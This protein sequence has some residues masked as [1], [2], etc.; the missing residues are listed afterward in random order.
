MKNIAIFTIS[1]DIHAGV[2]ADEITALGANCYVV[3]SDKLISHGGLSANITKGTY[4]INDRHGRAFDIG[5][6]DVV[7]WRRAVRAQTIES[8]D[9]PDVQREVINNDCEATLLGMLFA[10]FT[11]V[12]ISHPM[13]T[14]M[15]ANK[16]WQGKLAEECGLLHPKT[17]VSQNPD[18]VYEFIRELEGRIIIKPVHGTIKLPLYTQLL[19]MNNL[20]TRD[21]I[22]VC[23]TIYQELIPGK[24]HFRINIF[25]NKVYA[26]KLESDDLDW[27]P[28]LTIPFELAE[29]PH[30]LVWRLKRMIDGMG[31]RMGIVDMKYHEVNGGIYFLEVNPQGQFLFLQAITGFDLAKE[32]AHFLVNYSDEQHET[33]LSSESIGRF[34]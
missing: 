19:D 7:W 9:F 15:A 8:D 2:I 12:W 16:V 34:N 30:D 14:R 21:D 6:L 13:D 1:G 11:G 29:L 4:T 28:D 10:A 26:F 32:F 20:P 31:L 5:K 33:S 27:R 17:L 18:E 25:G 23:P 24:L 3:E 22:A